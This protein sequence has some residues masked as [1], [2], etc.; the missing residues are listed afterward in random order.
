M[1]LQFIVLHDVANNFVEVVEA[2]KQKTVDIELQIVQIKK[3]VP[4]EYAYSISKSQNG[5]NMIGIIII[6][7]IANTNDVL[8]TIYMAETS[9]FQQ[10]NDLSGFSIYSNL[11]P[12]E[13]DMPQYSTSPEDFLS[14]YLQLAEEILSDPNAQ[15]F[16][17]YC[18]NNPTMCAQPSPPKGLVGICNIWPDVIEDCE[19]TP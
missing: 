12:L 9:K 17:E 14:G 10:Y 1:V 13:H 2:T 5:I 6:Q 15:V 16:I 18:T 8:L 19:I 3:D 11:S 4:G 7:E